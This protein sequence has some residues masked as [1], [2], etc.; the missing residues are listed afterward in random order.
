MFWKQRSGLRKLTETI[1]FLHYQ[2]IADQAFYRLEID[3][4]ENSYRVGVVRPEPENAQQFLDLAGDAGSISLEIAD[5]L[6]PGLGGS[7]T[8]IPPPNFPDLFTPIPLPDGV[9]FQDVKTPQGEFV[10]GTSEKAWF[11][12]APRG[13]TEF[14][15]LHLTLSDESP[16]TILVNPFTGT[17]ET[18]PEYK[19]FEWT[20]ET[21]N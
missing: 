3:F 8:L 19:E 21:G 2:A 13:F 16:L 5:F 20:Y 4:K 14:A 1:S 11:H 12:F 10:R 7:H 6:S 17:T 15:V 9:I 18:F